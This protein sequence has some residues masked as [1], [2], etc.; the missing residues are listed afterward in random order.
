MGQNW[1]K[2]QLRAIHEK[3]SNILVAAAAGAGKTAVLVERIINKIINDGVDIDK[4]L[5][6]TFTNAAASEMRER[7]YLAISKELDKGDDA[8]NILRQMTLL[9]KSSIT[10]MHSFCLE[11]IRNNFSEIDIDPNFRIADKTEIELI[12]AETLNE[13][14]EEEY[15]EEKIELME[16]LESYGGSKDD[17]LIQEM[18]LKLYHFIQSNPWPKK[19]LNDM[20]NLMK[21]DLDEDFSNTIWGDVI[22]ENIKVDLEGVRDNIKKAIAIIR[23]DSTL[24]DKFFKLY[25]EDFITIDEMIKLISDKNDL[26]RWDKFYN[27]VN[28]I[29]FKSLPKISSKLEFD[30]EKKELVHGIRNEAKDVVKDIKEKCVTSYSKDIIEDI[31][32]VYPIM[33]Y[34]VYL[35]EAFMDKYEE[36]KHKKNIA[37]FGDLEHYCLQILTKKDENG[38]FIPSDI[39]KAYKDKFE[40]ILVDEYQDSNDIQETIIS[41]ISRECRNTPNV[42]MV[43]DVKQSIYR[44]R[45]AN[46]ELFLEKYN[47]YKNDSS[48]L[49]RKIQLFKNF[50]SKEVVIDSVNFIFEQVMSKNVGDLDYTKDEALNFG[51]I[52]NQNNETDVEEFTELH[53]IETKDTIKDEETT[54]DEEDIYDNVQCEAKVVGK[55]IL[56]L[57]NSENPYMVYD[58]HSG[59]YRKAEFRDIV[60]LL[61]TVKK[62]SETF[63]KEL[64]NMG[65]KA[66][67][68]TDEGFF[69]TVEILVVISFL[70]IIDN[71]IQDIP[72]LSVLRSPIIGLTANELA[73][74]RAFNKDVSIFEAVNQYVNK[75]REEKELKTTIQ[76]LEKFIGYYND[77]KEKSWYMP[78]DELIWELYNKTGYYAMVGAMS[79][80]EQRK[81]NLMILFEK[82]KQFE[83]TSYKG[84]FNFINFLDKLKNNSS[85]IASASILGENDNVVRIISIHK[86]K[87]LEFPIV[88]L[89]GCGKKVNLR[90]TAQSIIFHQKLGFGPDV[91]DYYRRISWPSALKLAIREQITKE[92]LSEEMRILYVAL[93]R[94]REKLII[95]GSVDNIEKKLNKW[96][97]MTNAEKD[98][99]SSYEIKKGR[100]FLDWIVPAVLRHENANEFFDELP[101][102]FE[103]NSNIIQS[104][105][106]WKVFLVNKNEILEDAKVIEKRITELQ[107]KLIHLEETEKESPDISKE[108]LDKLNWKYKYSG[109]ELIPSKISVTDIKNINKKEPNKII[110]KKPQ[111]LEEKEGLE[112]AKRGTIIHL[113]MQ[114]IN[115]KDNNIQ[116]QINE[117]IK[118]DL[119]TDV[120]A[121]SIDIDKIERFLDS[122]LGERIKKATNVYR[123]VPFFVTMP[124]NK[125][126][127]IENENID[128]EII[129]QGV[130]DCYFEEDDYLVLIDYK[131]DYVKDENSMEEIK[132]RYRDQV[133]NYKNVLEKLTQKK[134]KYQYIYLFFNGEVIEY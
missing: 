108:I 111:F 44:F 33:K 6:V 127:K 8:K 92:T 90:D 22:L 129:L 91:V 71:P 88:F 95:T 103:L 24:N 38:D 47:S 11:V 70:Q 55:R 76:K 113:V 74:I 65:I 62:W 58:K 18:V 89:S 50:R 134:V 43:G 39:A 63:V 31:N 25:S 16:L 53:L 12:K 123:E 105:S 29:D 79:R 101:L 97:G 131:S 128:E 64:Q 30:E 17:R 28:D 98:N 32:K 81:A 80:G 57:T 96:Q 56:E 20:T 116:N 120:E 68:D 9:E 100:S 15:E 35:V 2:E 86:S 99:I 37:D 69:K 52:F 109:I 54:S 121:K 67:A 104:N 126:Y 107:Q 114:H 5:V 41:M 125:L 102:G 119:I 10:T 124:C 110:I 34:L 85:D 117:M 72:M 94:A 7:I 118:K 84:L 60:I 61:R 122:S 46:P 130:I 48:S 59:E 77:L 51:A 112:A 132:E 40:E 27:S 78:T 42:F 66:F 1:T 3:D 73:D 14:F 36:K 115:L 23:T 82:A 93:T 87:G 75:K 4:L 133:T 21:V 45:Q 13:L 26:N 49:Y 106:K 83:K 19:W